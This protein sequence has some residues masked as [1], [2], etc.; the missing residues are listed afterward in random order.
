MKALL[1]DT[2]GELVGRKVVVL[3]A[4]L[5]VVLLLG[6]WG[7][8]EIR[9]DI[10]PEAGQG[11]DADLERLLEPWVATAFSKITSVFIFFAV[12]A[13]AGLMPRLVERGR[14]E[15]YLSKPFSRTQLLLGK[16]L[17]IWLVYG[18]VAFAGVLAVYAVTAVVHGVFDISILLLFAIYAIDFLVWVS[19]V[20]LAGVLSGSTSW[21]IMAAFGLWLAQWLLSAREFV[22]Q[23][24][25]SKAAHYVLEAFY[26]I[27]PKTDELGD[28]AV[29]LAVKQP[30]DSWLP[31][32]SALVF[33][34]VMSCLAV[35]V[36][37]RRD[38]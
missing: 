14:V 27:S 6:V 4:V 20:V 25:G 22:T 32:G 33:S 31:L 26:Y 15:F 24:T 28:V 7:T 19:V 1:L 30:V 9:Q 16:L 37:R 21:A 2:I 36:F 5:T 38:Y 11:G 12:L 35:W 3:F 18:V 23:L 13:S 29:S 34:V 10:S 8:W 17:S